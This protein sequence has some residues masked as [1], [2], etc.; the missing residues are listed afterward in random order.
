M[1]QGQWLMGLL[2]GLALQQKQARM[3]AM[4]HSTQRTK[5]STP[6]STQPG[7]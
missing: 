6:H 2:M 1:Q 5:L 7:G 4:Q 3:L